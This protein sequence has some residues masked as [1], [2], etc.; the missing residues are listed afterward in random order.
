MEGRRKAG[1]LWWVSPAIT[2]EFHECFGLTL[3]ERPD[4]DRGRDEA[5]ARA[6]RLHDEKVGLPISACSS[7]NVPLAEEG[8]GMGES[9]HTPVHLHISETELLNCTIPKYGLSYE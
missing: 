2:R 6:Q 4:L 5:L 1:R 7:R 9:P 8:G 3:E